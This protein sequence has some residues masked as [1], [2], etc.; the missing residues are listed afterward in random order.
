MIFLFTFS[1]LMALLPK[2]SNIM[3]WLP[4]SAT[5]K[6]VEK[7]VFVLFAIQVLATVVATVF[8]NTRLLLQNV[9]LRNRLGIY[10]RTKE[11]KAQ[12]PNP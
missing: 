12:I 2:N 10:L 7:M 8:I 6:G 9:A 1:I 5:Q 11:K 3:I 4:F